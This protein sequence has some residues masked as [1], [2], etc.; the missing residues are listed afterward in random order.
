MYTN[1]GLD[2]VLQMSDVIVVTVPLTAETRYMFG[3]RQF[4][5]MKPTAIFINIGRG[6]TTDTEALI[7]ALKN[8]VIGCAGLDVFEQEPLPESSPLWQ[9]DSVI[10]TP[11]NSGSTVHYE[12]RGMSIFLENLNHFLQSGRPGLNVVDFDKQY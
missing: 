11:H 9:M 1:E 6:G 4:A 7:E 3:A 2:E 10:V 8:G 5:L 12:D